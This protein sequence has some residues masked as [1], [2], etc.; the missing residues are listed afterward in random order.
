MSQAA[1]ASSP[2]EISREEITAEVNAWVRETGCFAIA[3]P[4]VCYRPL[5][6]LVPCIPL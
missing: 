6:P 1:P 3:P 4:S 5:V 2:A